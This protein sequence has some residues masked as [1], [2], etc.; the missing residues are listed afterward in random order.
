M[1]PRGANPARVT[2]QLREK[3]KHNAVMMQ[4]PI[5]LEDKLEGVVDLVTMKAYRFEGESGEKIVVGEIPAPL[6]FE[7][8]ARREV[9][10]RCGQHVQRRTDG[11]HPRRRRSP[12]RL[13]HEP[14]ARARSRTS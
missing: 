8:E 1:R 4:I 11:G 5:G 10:A 13:I 14:C 3:L 9:D 6:L 2:D 7:A 12:N